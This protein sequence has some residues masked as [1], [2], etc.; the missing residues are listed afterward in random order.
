MAWLHECR[1]HLVFTVP[2][3]LFKLEA[4]VRESFKIS[5]TLLAFGTI[6]YLLELRGWGGSSAAWASFTVLMYS[7]VYSLCQLNTSL[8]PVALRAKIANI[9]PFHSALNR[10]HFSRPILFAILNFADRYSFVCIVCREFSA[11]YGCGV[12]VTSLFKKTAFHLVGSCLML[13][14]F[15]SKHGLIN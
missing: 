13:G 8:S 10:I 2:A 15:G 12:S 14:C 9:R 6:M 11:T 7:L 5:D 4:F 3:A 1:V